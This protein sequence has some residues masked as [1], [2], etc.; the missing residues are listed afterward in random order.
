MLQDLAATAVTELELRREL[1]ERARI[2]SALRESEERFRTLIEHT[3]DIIT[4]VDES[5]IVR[6]GSPSVEPVLGYDPGGAGRPA[7]GR[8]GPPR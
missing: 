5:G 7:G 8:S 6:Y 4:I 3:S 1:T 2:E